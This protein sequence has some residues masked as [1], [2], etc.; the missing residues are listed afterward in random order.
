MLQLQY[1]VRDVEHNA[2]TGFAI[3]L[4]KYDGMWFSS[5]SRHNVVIGF[6]VFA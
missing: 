2:I 1:V 4:L 6:E 3:N 5:K